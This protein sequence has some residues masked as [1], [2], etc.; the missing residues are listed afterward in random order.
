[1]ESKHKTRA[2]NIN[3]RPATAA[4]AESIARCVDAAYRHYIQRIGKPPGP[5]LNDYAQVVRRHH[6]FV[7]E[8][9][10]DSSGMLAGVLVLMQ[11]VNGMLLDNLAVHPEHQRRG[12]GRRLLRLAESETRALGRAHLELYSHE[13]M[14]ESIDFYR[15]AGY[16]ET[17]R[18]T[19]HGYHRVYMRKMLA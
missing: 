18:R 11:T 8:V 4:D 17:A 7:A 16:V 6:V 19:E 13:R 14:T 12:L 3:L 5:M 15:R 2:A 1:M 9:D 10:G